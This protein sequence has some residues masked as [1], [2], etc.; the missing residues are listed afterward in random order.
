M[1]TTEQRL[2]DLKEIGIVID[3]WDDVFSD[4]DPRPLSE[5]TV[6]GDFVDELKKRYKETRRGRFSG[7]CSKTSDPAQPPENTTPF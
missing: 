1:G 7:T 5:R 4:F 6:S 2:R 3:S